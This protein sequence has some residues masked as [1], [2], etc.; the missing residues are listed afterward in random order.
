MSLIQGI[1]GLKT[2]VKPAADLPLRLALGVIFIAHGVDKF[3]NTFGSGGITT[4]I[5]AFASMGLEPAGLTAM[6]AS[7]AELLGGIL[8][9]IGLGTRIGA[10][11]IAATMVVAIFWVHLEGGL[12]AQDNGFEYPMMILGAALTLAMQGSG[13]FSLDALLRKRLPHIGSAESNTL[14]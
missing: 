1:E 3:T 11:L 12:F 10:L 14:L 2:A 4:T 13:V 8:V 7:T 5:D 9:F 6:V